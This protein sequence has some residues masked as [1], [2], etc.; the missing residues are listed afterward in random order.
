MSLPNNAPCLIYQNLN[1]FFPITLTTKLQDFGSPASLVD[2]MVKKTVG[3]SSLFI[4][5]QNLESSPKET[6]VD[7]KKLQLLDL[8]DPFL[9]G[10]DA[11]KI[12]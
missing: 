11:P 1:I 12:Y 6:V 3:C 9:G 4:I 7:L 8:F 10:Y 5:M 2:A